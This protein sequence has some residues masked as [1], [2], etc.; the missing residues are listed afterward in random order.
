MSIYW[1]NGWAWGRKTVKGVEYREPLGT[2]VKREAESAYGRWLATFDAGPSEKGTSFREAVDTFT[3][4]HLGTLKKSSQ[5]RYLV[6][7]LNLTPHFEHKL[8][9]DISRGDL[10]KFMSARRKDGVKD[11]TI[12]RDLAC[13]SSVFTIAADYELADANPV[14]PFL[15]AQKRRQQLNNADPRQRYLSHA[16]EL[17]LLTYA[18]DVAREPGAIRTNEKWMIAAALVGY[19][20]TGMRAQELLSMRWTWVDMAKLEITVPAE[21]AKSGKERGIPILPRF[22]KL[23]LRIPR[24]KHSDL[25]F[26]RTTAGRGFGDLNHTFQRYAAAVGIH[27][28]NLHD[29]RRTCGCRLLQDHK[30][31]MTIVSKWLG[32]ASVVTTEKIYAFL[33]VENLHDAVGTIREREN[34]LPQ[35]NAALS[36]PK[37]GFASKKAQTAAHDDFATIETQAKNAIDIKKS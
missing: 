19:I 21:Y 13:L 15:R 35:L 3:D 23:L 20:D 36:E 17:A 31:A 33:K 5:E 14:L 37:F 2:R 28:V 10:A 11:P 29:L 24:N 9:K 1:R 32:H 18:A 12:I 4:N 6:S 27:D 8:L 25:V 26:W 34:L 22:A 30:V 16:E 7:L